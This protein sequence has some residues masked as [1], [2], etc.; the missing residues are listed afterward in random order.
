LEACGCASWP[1]YEHPHQVGQIHGARV[2]RSHPTARHKPLLAL[3]FRSELRVWMDDEA[4]GSGEYLPPAPPL[5]PPP[6]AP[7]SGYFGSLLA[8]TLAFFG[9]LL[10]AFA[11]VFWMDFQKRR[12]RRFVDCPL[13]IVDRFHPI[14]CYLCVDTTAFC[15]SAIRAVCRQALMPTTSCQPQTLCTC[16]FQRL[17]TRRKMRVASS[18]TRTSRTVLLLEGKPSCRTHPFRST[19]RLLLRAPRACP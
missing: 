4:S 2:S 13:T 15:A 16:R 3:V 8:S 11:A 14:S 17:T 10:L 6:L 19:R 9:L 5:V 12:R 1:K 18:R 7:P